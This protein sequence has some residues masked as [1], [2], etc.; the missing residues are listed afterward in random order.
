MKLKKML[1]S[2]TAACLLA[3]FIPGTAQADPPLP[4][5]I[6]EFC[7]EVL[8][9]ADDALDELGEAS[10]DLLN[11][12]DEFEDC[13]RGLLN[14]GPVSCLI[15]IVNCADNANQDATQ[16]CNFFSNQ[17]GDAYE[18][19]LREARRAGPGVEGR[20]QEWLLTERG[21]ACLQ[22]AVIVT[23]TCAEIDD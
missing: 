9:D 18:D 10:R 14:N 6:A 22:P 23:S 2:V 8:R 20:F 15:E 12:G 16:A 4:G 3:V 17:L 13:Q 19:T 7:S 5:I 21:R 1:S 11:C